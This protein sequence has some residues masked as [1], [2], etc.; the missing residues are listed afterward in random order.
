MKH[1]NQTNSLEKFVAT[2]EP[3][4]IDIQSEFGEIVSFLPNWNSPTELTK[5]AYVRMHCKQFH[6][7]HTLS[8]AQLSSAHIFSEADLILH[9]AVPRNPIS[10]GL[11]RAQFNCIFIAGSSSLERSASFTFSCHSFFPPPIQTRSF[12]QWADVR[13][14][15]SSRSAVLRCTGVLCAFDSC[16]TCI[17]LLQL[18][19]VSPVH[20]EWR[21]FRRKCTSPRS[22]RFLPCIRRWMKTHRCR[23]FSFSFSS[24][25]FFYSYS[26]H[27]SFAL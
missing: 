25:F 23:R 19:F 13:D 11:G 26:L 2:N 27:R 10:F 22:S 16:E 8:S 12:V 7:T 21:R 6:A 18:I 4:A 5:N 17:C 1:V 24:C 20:S 14:G 3:R 9:S 15:F